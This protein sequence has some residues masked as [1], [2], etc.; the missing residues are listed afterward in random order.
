MIGI[1]GYSA[2]F[3]CYV[4]FQ[5]Q[6]LPAFVTAGHGVTSNT[7]KDSTNN[8]QIGYVTNLQFSGSVDACVVAFSPSSDMSNVTY[9]GNDIITGSNYTTSI[10]TNTLIFKEGDATGKTFGY[11]LSSSCTL[12][13]GGTSITDLIKS[14][15]YIQGGDSGGIMYTMINGN[16]VVVGITAAFGYDYSAQYPF[17]SYFCQAKNIVSAFGIIPY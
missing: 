10:A 17:R 6:Y 7:V 14:D 1:G 5:N 4:P 9:Y 15:C 8:T 11:V 3:R 2:G 16:N 13:Y 12:S